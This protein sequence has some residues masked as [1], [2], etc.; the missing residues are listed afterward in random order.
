MLFGGSTS[1]GCSSQVF[2]N[3]HIVDFNLMVSLLQWKYNET[4]NLERQEDHFFLPY[5]DIRVKNRY[6]CGSSHPLQLRSPTLHRSEIQVN[7]IDLF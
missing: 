7:I 6:S 5:F 4:A 3:P 1:G 2:S